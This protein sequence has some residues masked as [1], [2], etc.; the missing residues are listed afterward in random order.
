M[1]KADAGYDFTVALS[2]D[3]RLNSWGY[4][5]YGIVSN[6]PSDNDFV[7]VAVGYG[8]AMALKDNGDVVV[9]GRNDEGQLNTPLFDAP[10]VKIGAGMYSNW[11]ITETGHAYVWGGMTMKG[12]RSTLPCSLKASPRFNRGLSKTSPVLITTPAT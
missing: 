2:N 12:A 9:W 7:D 5:W 8:H 4:N 3:G 1:V 11:A 6:T 10:V